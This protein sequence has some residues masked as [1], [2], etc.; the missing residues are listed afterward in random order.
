MRARLPLLALVF[1]A[2][3]AVPPSA[4][5]TLSF[6]TSQ[7]LTAT[8]PLSLPGFV[9]A[10]EL[11]NDGNTD[12]VVSACGNL[13]A[14]SACPGTG[15][16]AIDIFD[17]SASGTFTQDVPNSFTPA[18]ATGPLGIA[19]GDIDHNGPRD[20]AV[21][22]FGSNTV[23]L[24]V[25][26]NAGG[27]GT[28]TVNVG[29]GPV[30]P[31][32]ADLDNDGDLDMATANQNSNNVSTSVNSGA[33]LAAGTI[34]ASTG[35]GT[36][37]TYVAAGDLNGDGKRDLIVSAFSGSVFV[38]RNTTTTPGTLT[39]STT[40]YLASAGA[41]QAAVPADLDGD[42]KLDIVAADMTFDRLDVSMGDGTAVFAG[43]PPSYPVGGK[44]PL[45]AVI[46]DV[47]N[48]GKLDAV[49][50]NCG[51]V[52]VGGPAN[53]GG[54]SVIKG[55]GTGA[56]GAAQ[57]FTVGSAPQSVAVADFNRDGALDIASAN[58]AS[59]NVAVLLARPVVA[60]SGADF[61]DQV[62]G[63]A[64]PVARIV[65]TN[66]GVAPLAITSAAVTGADFAKTEDG[67]T[68]TTVPQDGTC[69]IGVRLTPSAA[70]ARAGTLTLTDNAAVTTQALALS[71]NGVP[72]D[73]GPT[74]PAGGNGANGAD[75]APG[76]NGANGAPGPAG[77]KGAT[78]PPG[79][80]ATVTCKVG[81]V[82]SG[83]VKVTCTVT[84]AK[85]K[86]RVAVRLSR[87]GR[88]VASGSA[89]LARGRVAKTLSA[90]SA[91]KPGRYVLGLTFTAD[92][93]TTK[94][95]LTVLVG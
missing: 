92:G 43:I 24:R 82:K 48:D 28:A 87:G 54:V 32:L 85:A 78:G 12:L 41:I 66:T 11:G 9:A 34:A 56:F 7:T 8:P 60:A 10:A 94:R 86:S 6:S 20:I 2:L 84:K 52:C 19:I 13:G 72:A 46:A 44:G 14:A 90:K 4:G 21:A 37:P 29:T 40:S 3:L 35:A 50:A 39:F 63:R 68:G 95:A 1:S 15:N 26:N 31:V 93:T 71:G 59:N 5:A 75:G 79:R 83:K 91:V 57:Q 67:C 23:T 73:A 55:L 74:G 27:Y 30:M 45:Q 77:P 89:T 36:F 49:T 42:G 76:A 58:S 81:K 88:T 69:S 25:N 17:G 18:S 61:G 62:V 22:N 70:G 53:A 51:S 65:V 38:L 16:G 33:S 47:D 64:S 80:D